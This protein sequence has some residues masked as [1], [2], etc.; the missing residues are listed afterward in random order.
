MT[1]AGGDSVEVY[2][3]I[4]NINLGGCSCASLTTWHWVC[5]GDEDRMQQS[6]G[7]DTVRPMWPEAVTM[8]RSLWED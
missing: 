1:G 8:S 6:A 5:E 3:P 4:N 7:V 2:N